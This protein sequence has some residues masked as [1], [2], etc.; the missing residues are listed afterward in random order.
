MKPLEIDWLL[1]HTRCALVLG[2]VASNVCVETTARHAI[3]L[4]YHVVVAEDSCANW[5]ADLHEA[6]MKNIRLW[7]GKVATAADIIRLWN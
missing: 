7:L 1:E 4:D 2:G 6:A 5:H 3:M